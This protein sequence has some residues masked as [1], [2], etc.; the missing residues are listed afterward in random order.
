M[1]APLIP[2]ITA[3]ILLS[4][5]GSRLSSKY[6]SQFMLHPNGPNSPETL[7]LRTAFE[8]QLHKKSRGKNG[9][10]EILTIDSTTACYV[11]TSDLKIFLTSPS[12]ESELVLSY[13][14]EG[15]Y[16]ALQMVLHNQV[17]KRTVLDNLELLMLL[18]D[19]LSDGG[20]ILETNPQNLAERVLM[21]QPGEAGEGTPIGELT[22]GQAFNQIAG[23]AREQIIANMQN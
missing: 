5:D 7:A 12:T 20:R 9:E 14:L 17:D 22:I 1:S 11:Q 10:I 16:S 4:S 3:L 2:S 19:E 18:I 6:Y 15:F 8:K 23:Q 21:K 13:V